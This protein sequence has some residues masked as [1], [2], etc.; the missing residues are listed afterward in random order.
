MATYSIALAPEAPGMFSGTTLTP[1]DLSSSAAIA[2]DERSVPPPASAWMMSRMSSL[3]YSAA[4]SSE[5]GV[6][7]ASAADGEAESR[8]R[9]GGANE[10]GHHCSSSVQGPKTS[11]GFADHDTFTVNSQRRR[12]ARNGTGRWCGAGLSARRA[13]GASAPRRAQGG[14]LKTRRDAAGIAGADRS[15]STRWDAP[16]RADPRRD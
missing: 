13:P 15:N 1:R 5:T 16:T 6:H 14:Q 10:T 8:E 2:R 3:G 9:G 7:A 11:T 12:R 4:L